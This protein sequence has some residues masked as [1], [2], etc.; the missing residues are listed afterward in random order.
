MIPAILNK[1]GA[2]AKFSISILVSRT[3]F[4]AGTKM[5]TNRIAIVNETIV[6]N[7]DSDKNCLINEPL[8]AP[9]TFLIPTSNDLFIDLAVLRFM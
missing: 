2:D 1:I 4:N 7:I 9:I 8:C 6:I 3:L 5:M